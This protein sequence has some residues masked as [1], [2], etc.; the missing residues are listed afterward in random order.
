MPNDATLA[1]LGVLNGTSDGSWEQDN[2]L[3]LEVFS[4]EV[5]TAFETATIFK[6]LH[7]VRTIQ[8][9]KS[10][11]FPVLGKM[12]ARYHK[13]G[14]AILGSNN[15]PIGQRVIAIDD[16]LISDVFIYDLEDAKLHFDVRQ[17]YS[18]QLGVS[19]A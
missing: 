19:L 3:F 10:A 18:H 17:E 8:H 12:S 16:L 6:P 5:L 4:G 9:G 7:R 14:E 1:R 13:P 2:A 15:P 11:S